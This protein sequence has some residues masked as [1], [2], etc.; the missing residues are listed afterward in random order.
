MGYKKRTGEQFAKA[1][2][3]DG[4]THIKSFYDTGVTEDSI[5]SIPSYSSKEERNR[6][7]EQLSTKYTQDDIADMLDISQST[8]SNA[9]S[10]K[11]KKK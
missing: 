2:L 7:I 10:K 9:L 6:I 11:K 4:T 1:T 8:V 5:I 3:S